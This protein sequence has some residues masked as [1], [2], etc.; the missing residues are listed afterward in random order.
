VALWGMFA[1]LQE[2]RQ[3]K[4]EINPQLESPFDSPKIAGMGRCL[5]S[6]S[7]QGSASR[8]SNRNAAVR[9]SAQEMITDGFDVDG[10]AISGFCPISGVL[11]VAHVAD[12]TWLGEGKGGVR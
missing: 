6:C 7:P 2:R 10:N 12:I 11:H 4:L 1:D 5:G 3:P 9:G 8:D